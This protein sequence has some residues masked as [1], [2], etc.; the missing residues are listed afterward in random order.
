[1]GLDGR[2]A[3][4]G[5]L[6]AKKTWQ[7]D[8]GRYAEQNYVA[9][10]AFDPQT[11]GEVN[12]HE[13]AFVAERFRR[14][15]AYRQSRAQLYLAQE[16]MRRGDKV[17]ATKAAQRAVNQEPRNVAA[18]EALL[19]MQQSSGLSLVKQEATL[20][21]AARVLKNYPDLHLRFMRQVIAKLRERGQGSAAANEERQLAR[22]LR[23]SV[24]IFLWRKLRKCSV[25]RCWTTRLSCRY[26]CSK[27]F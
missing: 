13:L 5:Y 6:D 19:L 23:R 4:F 12:D 24:L 9:G 11:W 16:L 1:M 17:G 18:W 25:A 10:I 14:L 20:R 26:A 27:A 2:H 21:A 22:S 15:P 8:V 3:W 7:L